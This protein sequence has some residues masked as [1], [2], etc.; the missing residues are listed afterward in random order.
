MELNRPIIASFKKIFKE[1]NTHKASIKEVKEQ[2][3]DDAHKQIRLLRLR[4]VDDLGQ[5]LRKHDLVQP[6]LQQQKKKLILQRSLT[7]KKQ[8][9]KQK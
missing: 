6:Q 4:V 5:Q 7:N 8:T 2:D 3:F 9:S 1:K